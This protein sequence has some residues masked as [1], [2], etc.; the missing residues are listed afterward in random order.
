MDHK[1]LLDP[2]N[3]EVTSKKN[4]KAEL[5]KAQIA[6]LKAFSESQG[7]LQGLNKEITAE[8][9]GLQAR[10]ATDPNLLGEGFFIDF[11]VRIVSIHSTWSWFK[12]F[13]ASDHFDAIS[14]PRTRLNLSNFVERKK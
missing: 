6:A 11:S 9:S 4:P 5:T 13:S 3:Y 7:D 2:A 1:T 10:L 12:N 14:L 8:L